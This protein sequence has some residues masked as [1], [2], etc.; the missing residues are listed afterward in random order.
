MRNMLLLMLIDE[1]LYFHTFLNA[2]KWANQAS[3]SD[4][5][6]ATFSFLKSGWH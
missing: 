2:M 6:S 4:K 3:N 5:L 1:S